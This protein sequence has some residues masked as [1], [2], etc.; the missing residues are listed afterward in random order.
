MLFNRENLEGIYTSLMQ[1]QKQESDFLTIGE[2]DVTEVDLT[3][4]SAG[5]ELSHSHIWVEEHDET[6]HWRY[7]K[8][9]KMEESRMPHEFGEKKW[10]L[11]SESCLRGNGYT[12][13]CSACGYQETG[14]KPCV[15]GGEYINDSGRAYHLKKCKI[16]NSIILAKNYYYNNELYYNEGAENCVNSNGERITCEKKE[17]CKICNSI[18][19]GEHFINVRPGEMRCAYC[20]ILYGFY[21][22]VCD[23]RT[24]V[25]GH[26]VNKYTLNISINNGS[27]I[28]DI[29]TPPGTPFEDSK[30]E[31][32]NE[33]TNTNGIVVVSYEVDG[34]VY[35][36][37]Q[38]IW[39]GFNIVTA[40][41]KVIFAALYVASG[42]DISPDIMKPTVKVDVGDL[43][44]SNWQKSKSITV[45]GTEDFA[46]I[47][48][49]QII[50]KA[51]KTIYTG[52]SEVKDKKYSRVLVP[53]LEANESG[54]NFTVKVTDQCGNFTESTFNISKIDS[55]APKMT[56]ESE[57]SKEWSKTKE[58]TITAT[59]DG[60]GQVKISFNDTNNYKLATNNGNEYSRKYKFTGDV[61]GNV[62]GAIYLKDGLENSTTEFIDI[63]NLD[64]TAPTIKETLIE[65]D[66][67]LVIANDKNTILNAEGSG[68]AKFR[69]ITKDGTREILVE[70]LQTNSQSIQT[71]EEGDKIYKFNLSDFEGLTET[72]ITP[73]DL[74]ENE[75]HA[76][77]VKLP[78]IESTEIT[79]EVTNK[80]VD[81]E[82]K[83]T[84]KITYIAEIENYDGE[85]EIT[86]IDELPYYIDTIKTNTLT[87]LDGGTYDEGNKKITWIEHISNNTSSEAIKTKRDIQTISGENITDEID[88]NG[89]RTITVVKNITIAFRDINPTGKDFT[90]TVKGSI[91]LGE[92]SQ[93]DE[94]EEIP[95]ET[96]TDF[97]KA[98]KV[99][100]T[101]E[102]GNNK[103]EEPK[104]IK[105]QVK[106]VNE[107][108]T[109]VQEYTVG[110]EQNWTHIFTGLPK[111]DEQ[112]NEIEYTVDEEEV[113]GEDL[114]YYKKEIEQ[115]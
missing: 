58:V 61:Y 49:I 68:I 105:L 62:S 9:C 46:D 33:S 45:S 14:Q 69:I 92:T 67:M 97:T 113:E 56:S 36:T 57:T 75:G 79:A 104:Q 24:I 84:Y 44:D 80:I 3:G 31:W 48:T 19:G 21:S 8:I 55:V 32:K 95:Y 11:G 114:N 87:E 91:A 5:D 25:N 60:I 54:E 23:S 2:D 76:V 112:G 108:E 98:I 102:H 16:C 15:W 40:D 115:N 51:N 42:P 18:V 82:E 86:I 99:T 52:S 107:P 106:K 88:E 1:P 17:Q 22:S 70:E 4:I 7:C 72:T 89:V 28:Q 41:E 73:V 26:V 38:D 66:K 47:V 96:Q 6:N 34:N 93:N 30:I 43:T 37:L 101:W 71:T 83:V 65:N 100:K 12:R 63:Y 94:T 27:K 53:S 10:I 50:D 81:K 29:S 111:Y 74:V 77:T 90:S 85:V 103:Y 110:E 59:D 35:K 78:H 64:N 13:V 109:V 20:G 39:V